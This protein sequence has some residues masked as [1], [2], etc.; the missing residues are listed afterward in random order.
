MNERELRA[1]QSPT[2]R[3]GFGGSQLAFLALVFAI[4]PVLV[5][6]FDPPCTYTRRRN[7]QK[8]IPTRPITPAAMPAT[9]R[10]TFRGASA[11]PSACVATVRGIVREA[12]FNPLSEASSEASSDV[13]SS[14]SP[15]FADF[16]VLPLAF[17]MAFFAVVSGAPTGRAPALGSLSFWGVSVVGSSSLPSEPPLSALPLSVSPVSDSPPVLPSP[18]WS[19]P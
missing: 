7:S 13:S 12:A 5:C 19:P 11:V 6:I 2:L 14:S 16:L 1:V 17:L 10:T 8:P 4:V 15:S 18:P 3:M 9:G